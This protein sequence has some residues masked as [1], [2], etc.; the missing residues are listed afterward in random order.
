MGK[1][2]YES[3]VFER[4][5]IGP[6][7]FYKIVKDVASGT[8]AKKNAF[9]LAG[10]NPGL[11]FVAANVWPAVQAKE[12]RKVVFVDPDNQDA[13]LTLSDDEDGDDGEEEVV[14][15]PVKVDKP[16]EV[17]K[18]E[19]TKVVAPVKVVEPAKVAPKVEKSVEVKDDFFDSISD[20]KD[21]S[22]SFLGDLFSD[23]SSEE[24]I[25]EETKEDDDPTASLF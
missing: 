4:V 24:I 22:G 8:E 3:C 18:V 23:E 19:P 2:Q 12:I 6:D 9:E 14:V 17:K 13:E 15:P 25:A 11:V 21:E 10:E 1:R 5:L 20:K 7:V 16:I